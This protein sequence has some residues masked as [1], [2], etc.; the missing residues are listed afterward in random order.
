MHKLF[1]I[2]LLLFSSRYLVL[3]KSNLEGEGEG[4][5]IKDAEDRNDEEEFFR[6]VFAFFNKYYFQLKLLII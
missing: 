4:G 6:Y 5:F 1:L 3:Y 2:I